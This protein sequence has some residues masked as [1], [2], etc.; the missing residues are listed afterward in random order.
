M[1]FN[2]KELSQINWH[3]NNILNFNQIEINVASIRSIMRDLDKK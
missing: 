2:K 1:K 3:L